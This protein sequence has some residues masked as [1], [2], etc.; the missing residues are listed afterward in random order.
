[1]SVNE[2]NYITIQGWMIN[3]LDLKGN[4]LLIYAIIY[5]FS[6]NNGN[7]F[8]GSL[9]YLADWTCTTKKSAFNNVKSLL[10]KGLIEKT[11]VF[12]GSAKYCTYKVTC[13]DSTVENI[14][15]CRSKN[16]HGTVENFT[17]NNTNN[18]NNNISKKETIPP[19]FEEAKKY[20]QEK[21]YTFGFDNWFYHYESKAWM[22][23]KTKI[24]SWKATMRTWDLNDKKK[25]K[26]YQSNPIQEVDLLTRIQLDKEKREREEKER[27][28]VWEEKYSRYKEGNKE[29]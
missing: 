21:G 12:K 22:M 2:K 16:Y 25:N 19:D 17:T 5:G 6:Q 23:G 8:N 11:E 14:S 1:M 28:R 9:Q 20:Y 18:T 26:S 4:E 7:E 27:Q 29:C 13:Q 15:N 10:E 3:E 24:K